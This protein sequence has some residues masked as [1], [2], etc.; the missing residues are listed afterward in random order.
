[1]GRRS[2]AVPSGLLAIDSL[3]LFKKQQDLIGGGQ[4]T[5]DR[6]VVHRG[7]IDARRRIGQAEPARDITKKESHV[8]SSRLGPRSRKV[9]TT[10]GQRTQPVQRM[11]IRPEMGA[12]IGAI[13]LFVIFLIVAPPFREA[14]SLAPCCMPVHTIASWRA[15][16]R[17]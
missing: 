2:A 7:N 16:W 13:A 17:C 14:A 1:V 12:L 6:A 9:S 4:P 5:T 11:L 8:H 3:W 10:N 15:A